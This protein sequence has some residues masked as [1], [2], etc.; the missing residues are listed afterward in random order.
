MNALLESDWYYVLPGPSRVRLTDDLMR[1]LS[2][3]HV[4]NF[5]DERIWDGDW[6]TL[7]GSEMYRAIEQY[8]TLLPERSSRSRGRHLPP[9][10]QF[11]VGQGT[12]SH[13]S[14]VTECSW[15]CSFV[16]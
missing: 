2:R 16:Q 9:Q 15:V 10:Y 7:L 3:V 4:W 11:S 12:V 13:E 6:E 1:H 8:N 14:S 5:L